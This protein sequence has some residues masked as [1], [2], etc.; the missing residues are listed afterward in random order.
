MKT[1]PTFAQ[2]RLKVEKAFTGAPCL[3]LTE[4]NETQMVTTDT[5]TKQFMQAFQGHSIYLKSTCYDTFLAFVSWYGYS[6]EV[7][8]ID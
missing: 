2:V 1:Q 6:I 5:R 3:K 8:Q 4:Y 7:T